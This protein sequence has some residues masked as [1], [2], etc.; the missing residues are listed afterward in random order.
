MQHRKTRTFY[1]LVI[2]IPEF[3]IKKRALG[4]WVT[5]PELPFFHKGKGVLKID[6]SVKMP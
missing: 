4:H 5:G 1:I 3:W 6:Q 2:L